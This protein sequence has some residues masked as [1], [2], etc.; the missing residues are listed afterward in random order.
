M[1]VDLAHCTPHTCLLQTQIIFI[2]VQHVCSQ[3]G[4]LGSESSSE[5]KRGASSARRGQREMDTHTCAK[6]RH[7]IRGGPLRSRTSEQ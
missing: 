3:L 4:K 2:G 1:R 6:M 5:A 7:V